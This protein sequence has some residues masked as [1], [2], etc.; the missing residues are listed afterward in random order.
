MEN[1]GDRVEVAILGETAHARVVGRGT[2]RVGPSMKQFGLSAF[3]RGCDRLVMD[4]RDCV[5]MDSTFMGVLAGL[6]TLWRRRN[7][8][9]VLSNMSEKNCFLVKMLGLSHLVR[10]DTGESPKVPVVEQ[11]LDTAADKRTITETMITAHEAL[12]EVAPEN[13]VKFK[14][15]LTYLKEDLE[16]AGA[17]KG[18]ENAAK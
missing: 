6:A 8:E 13:L 16:R 17:P 11:R 4:M 3:D 2:F 9:V 12:V 15:V 7:G 18:A 1:G 14:D 5:G 10:M